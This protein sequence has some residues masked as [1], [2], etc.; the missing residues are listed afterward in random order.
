M[1]YAVQQRRHEIGVHLASGAGIH[2]IR[3]MVL[4]DGMKLVSCDIALVGA[5]A[6]ALAGTLTAFLFGVRPHDLVTFAATPAGLVAFMAAW[7]PARR[8]SRLDPAEILRG[9]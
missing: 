7:I 3:T 5:T 1:A 6:A 9:R 4:P 2:Q 8:A